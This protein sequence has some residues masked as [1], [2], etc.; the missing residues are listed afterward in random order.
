[1]D[2][3]VYT[4]VSKGGGVDGRD[5]TDKGGKVLAASFDKKDLEKRNNPWAE[6]KS[7]V[8]DVDAEA[9]V[10]LN[11]LTPLELLILQ[12][13]VLTKQGAKKR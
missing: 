11:K 2:Q 8:I 4:L 12:R 9:R 6:I 5:F 7:E 3:I 13:S 1:M 10:L